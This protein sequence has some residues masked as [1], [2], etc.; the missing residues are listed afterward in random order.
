LAYFVP[1]CYLEIKHAMVE[2]TEVKRKIRPKAKLV[3][4]QGELRKIANLDYFRACAMWAVF[5][6][7]QVI[8][9]PDKI[10]IGEGTPNGAVYGYFQP[11]LGP[12]W[13]VFE[14]F[15]TYFGQE[16]LK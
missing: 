4:T 7:K 3:L 11:I 12:F 8:I 6:K 1:T 9:D 5:V 2:R 16:I 15:G 14:P 10:V 13:P